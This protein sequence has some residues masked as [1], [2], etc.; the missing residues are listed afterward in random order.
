MTAKAWNALTVEGK[1][2]ALRSEIKGLRLALS[3]L[4]GRIDEISERSTK[5]FNELGPKVE[6]LRATGRKNET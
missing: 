2:D 3:R 4:E 1:L 6:A 5:L